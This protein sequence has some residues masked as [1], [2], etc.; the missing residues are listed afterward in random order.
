VTIAAQT[1]YGFN[2]PQLKI[3]EAQ[4]EVKID[5][6]K[7]AIQLG[8][9]GKKGSADDLTA[10]LTGDLSLSPRVLNSRMNVKAHFWLSENV[11]RAFVLLDAILAQGKQPDGS[12]V[13]TLTGQLTSPVPL[14]QSGG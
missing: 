7:A 1:L 14:P 4:F 11:K 2:I 12:F 9:I 13:Y 6:G 10:D 3:S 5:K 8:K